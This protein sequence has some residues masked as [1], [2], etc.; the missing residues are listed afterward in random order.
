M[1]TKG[2]DGKLLSPSTIKWSQ[3]V[4][5]KPTVYGL[6]NYSIF[7]GSYSITFGNYSTHCMAFKAEGILLNL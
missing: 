7:L 1:E 2:E 3:S 4:L 6:G 5:Y